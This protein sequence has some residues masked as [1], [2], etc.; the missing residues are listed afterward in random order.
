MSQIPHLPFQDIVI[1][2]IPL[3]LSAGLFR[4]LLSS[5]SEQVCGLLYDSVYEINT[6]SF[7]LC[8]RPGVIHVFRNYRFLEILFQ[9]IRFEIWKLNKWFSAFERYTCEISG[10]EVNNFQ[11]WNDLISHFQCSMIIIYMSCGAPSLISETQHI[12]LATAISPMILIF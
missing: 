6:I 4:M 9:L 3:L 7:S 8:M 12:I 2:H 11:V 5:Q 10:N 1:K